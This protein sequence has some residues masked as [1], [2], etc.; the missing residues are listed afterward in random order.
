MKRVCSAILL[1]GAALAAQAGDVSHPSAPLVLVDGSAHFGATFAA[2]NMGNTFADRFS[3]TST[4]VNGLDALVSSISRT[5]VTGLDV[6]GFDLYGSG[7]LVASGTQLGTGAIDLWSLTVNNLGAGSYYVQ[8]TGRMVSP[9]AASYGA[10]INL[11]PVP[12]PATYL[13]LLCGLGL[14]GALAIRR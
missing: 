13:L 8:V 3:F 6:T 11:T 9:T 7:G 10:N 2:G 14:L 12:E 1:S 4:G 5:A